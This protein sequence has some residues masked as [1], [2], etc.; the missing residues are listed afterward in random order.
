MW[1]FQYLLLSYTYFIIVLTLIKKVFFSLLIVKKCTTLVKIHVKY[2]SKIMCC[3]TFVQ[4]EDSL[5]L[6]LFRGADILKKMIA[7]V[8][9]LNLKLHKRCYFD[10]VDSGFK[11]TQFFFVK[12]LILVKIYSIDASRNTCYFSENRLKRSV[13]NQAMLRLK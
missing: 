5:Q 8:F 7:L 10:T 2:H 3:L 9:V 6:P 13:S 11:Q 1:G 12:S 4:I